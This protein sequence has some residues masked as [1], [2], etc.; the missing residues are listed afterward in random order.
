ME[1]GQQS[2]SYYEDRSGEGNDGGHVE[3]G[4]QQKDRNSHGYGDQERGMFMVSV[5]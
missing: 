3:G 4:N 2:E 1:Q 5:M